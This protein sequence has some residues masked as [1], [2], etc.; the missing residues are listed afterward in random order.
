MGDLSIQPYQAVADG[1]RMGIA[2]VFFTEVQSGF[3]ESEKAQELAVNVID[4]L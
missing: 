4:G 1:L 2:K 3:G